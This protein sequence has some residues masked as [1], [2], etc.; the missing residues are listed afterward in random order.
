MCVCVCVCV[1]MC[2]D[3]KVT[4]SRFFIDFAPKRTIWE[5]KR[6]DLRYF[7][8]LF[9]YFLSFFFGSGF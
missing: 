2:V 8:A 1:Y 9:R 7:W 3:V 5:P 4:L 6:D